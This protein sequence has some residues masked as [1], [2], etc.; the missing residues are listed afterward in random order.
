MLL[1]NSRS[2]LLHIG[3]N[4]D[5]AVASGIANQN[6]VTHYLEIFAFLKIFKPWS[7]IKGIGRNIC[8]GIW[9]CHITQAV[10]MVKSAISDLRNPFRNHHGGKT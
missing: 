2:N 4:I 1:K 10:A 5:N 9:N 7:L 3:R 8:H 6:P